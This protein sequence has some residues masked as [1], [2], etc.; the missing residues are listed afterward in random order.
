MNVQGKINFTEKPELRQPSLIC[1][2]SGWVDGGKAATGTVEYLIKVLRPIKFAELPIEQFHI[3]Q[4]PGQLSLR[5]Q[6]R[7]DNGLI[8]DHYFPKNTF[9]YWKNPD[10]GHDL[11]LFLG[12]EPNFNWADYTTSILNIIEQYQVNKVFLL[13]GVL[14]RIPHTKDPSISCTISL[15]ELRK[16]MANQ[17]VQFSNYEGPGSFSSTLLYFCRKKK[18]PAIRFITRATYYPEFNIIIPKNPKSIRSILTRLTSLL[19]IDIDFS[20]INDEVRE[21]EVKMTMVGDQNQQFK[22]YVEELERNYQGTDYQ[23]PLNITADEAVRIAEELLKPR[24]ED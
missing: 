4:V 7:I 23:E 17:N 16:E 21:F 24:D 9:Y 12:T 3:F 11:I 1:G 20:D 18:I 8:T 14:D 10:T 5:P 22:E 6:I 15:S 2:I 19:N 13:G